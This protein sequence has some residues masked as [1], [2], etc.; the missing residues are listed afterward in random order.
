MFK[1]IP[2]PEPE[3]VVGTELAVVYPEV[4]FAVNEIAVP[5][6]TVAVE[7]GAKTYL[8]AMVKSSGTAVSAG[9]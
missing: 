5:D 3:V 6:D 8:M 9:A 1:S 7:G 2:V 4:P